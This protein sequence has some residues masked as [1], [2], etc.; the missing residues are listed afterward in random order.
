MRAVMVQA[1]KAWRQ[2][3]S[4]LGLCSEE[5][6]ITYIVAWEMAE[7]RMMAWERQEAER[8]QKR[9]RKDRS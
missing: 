5:D 3:P 2:R 1:A 8:E 9:G 7:S 4:D 6:D